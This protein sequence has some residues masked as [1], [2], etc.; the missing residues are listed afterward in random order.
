[1][2]VRVLFGAS[3]KPCKRRAF[4]VVGFVTGHFVATALATSPPRLAPI[5]RETGN[6]CDTV[7]SRV[8]AARRTRRQ[9]GPGRRPWARSDVAPTR[10]CVVGRSTTPTLTQR[11]PVLSPA[12][13]TGERDRL[14]RRRS[15]ARFAKTMPKSTIGQPGSCSSSGA[16]ARPG[17]EP[18]SARA[19]KQ[20]PRP[21]LAKRELAKFAG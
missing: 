6:R 9:A 11:Q 1:V 5:R 21:A 16:I 10:A 15:S 18:A 17:T 8:L 7:Q 3:R 19:G 12:A 13:E 14:G 4:V 2:E 20:A